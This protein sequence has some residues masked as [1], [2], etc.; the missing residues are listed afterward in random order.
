MLSMGCRVLPGCCRSAVG[1]CQAVRTCGHFQV[2][3]GVRGCGAGCCAGHLDGVEGVLPGVPGG[4]IKHPWMVIASSYVS[5][6]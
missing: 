4:R 2:L 5:E 3:P 1:C 6:S